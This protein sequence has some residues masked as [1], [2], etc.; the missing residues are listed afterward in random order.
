MKIMYIN[1]Y[2]GVKED[3]RFQKVVDFINK[4]K[5]DIL[6][7]SELNNWDKDN[8]AKLKR[9][10]KLTDFREHIFCK[11]KTGF[12]LGLFSNKKVLGFNIITEEMWHGA[13]LAKFRE[14]NEEIEVI[15]THL[16]PENEDF[17]LK[18]IKIINDHISRNHKIVLMGDLNSLSFKDH[19]D[20]KQLLKEMKDLGIKKFG[21]EK[22]RFDAINEI[23]DI[24]FIDSLKIFTDKF[25]YS[26]PTKYNKDSTHF[27]KLRLDYM[28]ITKP[29]KE[30]VV[31]TRILRDK[32]TNNTSD[33]FPILME[34]K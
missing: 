28:F 11:A 18:E 19:Y 10:K 25:E 29:L 21:V 17:R 1:L 22:I 15:L 24:G 20:E 9:F 26:V 6:G 14:G 31:N 7:L 3:E 27:T 8:L 4:Y 13:I 12:N 34:I 2:A 23:E 33:H 16:S 32:E 30:N 5:P